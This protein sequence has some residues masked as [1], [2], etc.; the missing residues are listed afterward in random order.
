[1]HG[2]ASAARPRWPFSMRETG[3]PEPEG[4]PW[5]AR[6]PVTGPEGLSRG[7]RAALARALAVPRSMGLHH[8]PARCTRRGQAGV[9]ALPVRRLVAGAAR[10]RPRGRGRGDGG[11]GCGASC[12]GRRWQARVA[13][14]AAAAGQRCR[15][16]RAVA[17][18]GFCN[19]ETLVAGSSDV[20]SYIPAGLPP[21][22]MGRGPA[23]RTGMLHHL[24]AGTVDRTSARGAG[25]PRGRGALGVPSKLRRI[26]HLPRERGAK[27]YRGPRRRAAE[28]EKCHEN[29]RRPA[30]GRSANFVTQRPRPNRRWPRHWP[31]GGARHRQHPSALARL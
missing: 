6:R 4:V 25:G 23:G 12:D 10:R 22:H 28:P 27:D 13:D 20:V 30:H 8:R 2:Q 3:A 18:G 11:G 1:M 17:S 26:R 16:G 7:G 14:R 5:T 15:V 21:A 29:G 19:Q 24:I 31:N 9:S